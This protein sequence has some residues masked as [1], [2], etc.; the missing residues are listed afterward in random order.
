MRLEK[1]YL[2]H[3]RNYDSKLIEFGEGVQ[4]LLGRNAIGKTNVLEAIFLLATGDSF[5]A[6]KIDEMVQWEEEVAHVGGKVSGLLMTNDQFSKMSQREV[7][8]TELNVVLTRG[9]VGGEKARKRQFKVNGVPRQKQTFVG[10]MIVVAF[11][12]NDLQLISGSPT[13]RRGYLDTV[14]S[15]VDREYQRSLMSYE[16]ALRRRNKMLDLI[17]EGEVAR[18]ALIFWDQL[19]V[20]EGNVLTDKRQELI[21]FINESESELRVL[22]DYSAISEKRLEQY[23]REEVLAGY[24]LVGPHKDDFSV[25]STEGRSRDLAIYGSRGEQRMGVLWLKMRE[26]AFVEKMK[27][28]RPILLLDDIFSELDREHEAQVWEM[29]RQQQTIITTT[30]EDDIQGNSVD[31]IQLG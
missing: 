19:L 24:T 27:S 31:F 15:Q 10:N 3:F 1:L 22:Y 14:L 7:D 13:R 18:S 25:E 12:P 23:S 8:E 2:Q 20:K 11:F 5:R 26:M 6:G 17:R 21:Q 28:T 30:E 9:M 16:K 29:A 4:V